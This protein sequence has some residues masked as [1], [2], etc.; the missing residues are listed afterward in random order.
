M[1]NVKPID[2]PNGGGGINIKGNIPNVARLSSKAKVMLVSAAAV[3][4]GGIVIGTLTAGNHNTKAPEVM[5]ATSM[6]AVGS[7]EAPAAPEMPI[8][9]NAPELMPETAQTEGKEGELIAKVDAGA[10]LNQAPA[11][12]TPEAQFKEWRE[13]HRYQRLQG[14]ILASEAALTAETNKSTANMLNAKPSSL[15]NLDGNGEFD[16]EDPVQVARVQA[17][18]TRNRLNRMQDAATR[19][20]GVPGIGATSQYQDPTMAELDRGASANPQAQNQA[21]LKQQK[22]MA[23]DGYLPELKKPAVGETSL[24]A[25]SVIPAVMITGINS[26]LPGSVSA[27]VRQTVYD[28][29]D[30]NKV[31]I[32]AGTKLVGEYS[33]ELGYGQKRVL[34]AWNHLIFPNGATINLKGM[35]GGDGQGKSGFYDEVDN[36]YVRTFGSAIL[37]S[38]LNVGVQLSQPQNAGALNTPTSGSQAAAAAAQSLNDASARVLN[39]NLGI[40][41]TLVIKPGYSFNV[42]VNKTMI[43]PEYEE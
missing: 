12:I 25:G 9:V 21:F 4:A 10:G 23:D 2:S 22:A 35:L 18:Q 41:P 20:S 29:R 42:L 17:E 5:A 6:D 14:L 34:V 33:S 24:F 31:L 13:K 3:V 36:H 19:Q 7:I 40:Q 27:Q 1:S 11:A 38:L 16:S 15:M 8:K 37:M 43:M 28:S 30:E 32:P 39:K 26:D